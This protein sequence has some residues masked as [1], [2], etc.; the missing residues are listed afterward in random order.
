MCF[1]KHKLS[2]QISIS[3]L[4]LWTKSIKSRGKERE[5]FLKYHELIT[6]TH[7]DVRVIGLMV[8]VFVYLPVHYSLIE[9]NTN[10]VGVCLT[11][12]HTV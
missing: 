12:L 9:N 2:Y 11:G 10:N 6:L 8:Y 4:K 7:V 3:A 1:C 5:I